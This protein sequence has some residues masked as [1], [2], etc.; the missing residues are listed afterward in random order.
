MK[1]ILLC[2]ITIC[3]ITFTGCNSSLAIFP[4][5]GDTYVFSIG[6]SN[7]PLSEA[8]IIMM[9]FKSQYEQYYISVSGE[10]F[11]QQTITDNTTFES[12]IRNNV[13]MTEMVN[14]QALVQLAKKNNL[15]LT[16]EEEAN[17]KE[18]GE[19]YYNSLNEDEKEYCNK[20]SDSVTSLM[21]KYLLAQKTITYLT[22]NMSNEV[23][24]NEAR[25]MTIQE[26]FVSDEQTAK[27]LLEEI[28]KGSSF[29]DLAKENNLSSKWE[30]NVSRY[31]LSDTFRDIVFQ[32]ETGE[33]TD[34]IQSENGYHIIKCIND[35]DKELSEQNK[36]K[37]LQ[38]NRYNEWKDDVNTFLEK[39]P[40]S[41]NE[42]VWNDCTF[43]YN[44]NISNQ[45]FF[46]IYEKYFSSSDFSFDIE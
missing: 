20:Q 14:L 7:F 13:I 9:N 42:R 17:A 5:F 40:L 26:I 36:K 16:K 22:Q 35:Y 27:N 3:C 6:S 32:L 41:I 45:N 10:E 15:S 8:K 29:E 12:Y 4:A 43:Y 46:T 31:D 1:K 21:E 23:S 24:D 11:W 18:A 39:N 19:E 28:Q 34:I 38:T 44:E 37:I 25:V 30:Y 33:T 2:I